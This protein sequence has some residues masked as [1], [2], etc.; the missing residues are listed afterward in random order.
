MRRKKTSLFEEGALDTLRAVTEL[1]FLALSDEDQIKFL[2]RL[3]KFLKK[4][5]DS[6]KGS[7]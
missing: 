4:E 2:K 7:C 3:D 6:K 5:I 1:E